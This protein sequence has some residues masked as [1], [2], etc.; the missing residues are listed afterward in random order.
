MRKIIS[1]MMCLLMV[2][3]STVNVYALK[4]PTASVVTSD[5]DS[6]SHYCPICDGELIW[7]EDHDHWFCPECSW[8]HDGCPNCGSELEGPNYDHCDDCGWH[9]DKN[10]FSPST[11]TL[12]SPANYSI[13]IFAGFILLAV[14][15]G[16]GFVIKF[17]KRKTEI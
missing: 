7:E 16:T 14:G 3:L 17:A 15:L 4:S 9:V 8:P 2:L 5:S 11:S 12:G 13:W 1:V 6:N 10:P